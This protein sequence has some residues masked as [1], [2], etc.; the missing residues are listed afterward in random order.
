MEQG[1]NKNNLSPPAIFHSKGRPQCYLTMIDD[2]AR[3]IHLRKQA[4][5][6]L[7]FYAGCSNGFRPALYLIEKEIGIPSVK[8]SPIRKILVDHGLI[9]YNREQRYIYIAWN[10]INAFAMLEKPLRLTRGKCVFS[11][12]LNDSVHIEPDIKIKRAGL[13]YRIVNPRPLT[14]QE[15]AFYSTLENMT[16]G[17]YEFMVNAIREIEFPAI[18]PPP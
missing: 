18:Q 13:K 2:C 5:E 6:L 3:N 15:E 4:T 17:E 11:P 10:R 9:D 1:T 12:V 14:E 16:E 8:V 7:K